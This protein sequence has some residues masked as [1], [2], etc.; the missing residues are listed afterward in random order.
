MPL[1][2]FQRALLAELAKA[3]TDDRYLAGGA[4]MHFAPSS[5]R[6][7]DDLDFFHDSDARV[8]TAFAAGRSTS[9]A[10]TWWSRST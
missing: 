3:P 10:S 4:A 9:P 2:K 7:S 5:T 8:A 6:Y 1:S